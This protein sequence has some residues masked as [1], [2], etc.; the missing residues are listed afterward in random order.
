[1]QSTGQTRIQA[2]QPV[3]L[4][5]RMTANSLGSFFR[6]LPAPLAMRFLGLEMP[7]DFFSQSYFD[8]KAVGNKGKSGS[9]SMVSIRGDGPSAGVTNNQNNDGRYQGPWEK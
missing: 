2:S 6:T 5:A 7:T 4:S 9:L 3:Q 8:K 1:M